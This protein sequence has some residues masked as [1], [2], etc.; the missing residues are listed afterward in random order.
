MFLKTI[1]KNDLYTPS[2]DYRKAVRQLKEYEDYISKDKQFIRTYYIKSLIG[3]II[4]TNLDADLRLLGAKVK[5]T[6]SYLT[7]SQQKSESMVSLNEYGYQQII[8]PETGEA[9]IS[10]RKQTKAEIEIQRSLSLL[11]KLQEGKTSLVHIEYLITLSSDTLDELDDISSTVI[12]KAESYNLYLES[13]LWEQKAMLMASMGLRQG[14]KRFV[15]DRPFNIEVLYGLLPNS[16]IS[17]YSANGLY[18]GTHLDF[19][20]HITAQVLYGVNETDVKNRNIFVYGEAGGGKTYATKIIGDQFLINGIACIYVDPKPNPD[21]VDYIKARGGKVYYVSDIRMNIFREV[22]ILQKKE[23]DLTLS[24]HKLIVDNLCR[25]ISQIVEIDSNNIL[26][27][28]IKTYEKQDKINFEN[29]AKYLSEEHKT[30]LIKFTGSLGIFKGV[31]DNENET[32][33]LDYPLICFN[34]SDANDSLTKKLMVVLCDYLKKHIFKDSRPVQLIIDEAHMLTDTTIIGTLSAMARS[35]NGG[36]TAISQKRDALDM[37]KDD[38]GLSVGRQNFAIS[39]CFAEK[40]EYI[41]RD[42]YKMWSD[43]D[44]YR[45]QKLKVGEFFLETSNGELYPC[46]YPAFKHSRDLEVSYRDIR[47]KRLK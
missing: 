16:G 36:I 41:T 40:K 5:T 38:K 46:K 18:V 4:K 34:I 43:D 20:T 19:N 9:N 30:R 31:F 42:N 35:A 23:E 24:E 27:A 1:T 29:I 37:M 39:F 6:V 7:L 33:D 15:I 8:N 2:L 13:G 22:Q 11:K 28:V 45:L 25:L 17:N 14:F 32:I 3:D 12:S 10:A 47:E 21:Y 26:D 44:F